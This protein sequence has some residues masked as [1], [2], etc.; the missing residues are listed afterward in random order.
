[1]KT[2]TCA[3]CR[4]G[5]NEGVEAVGLIAYYDLDEGHPMR[6]WLC[7]QHLDMTL[8]YNDTVRV[9]KNAPGYAPVI[10]A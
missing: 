10:T 5:E 3:S 4:R 8:E 2:P 7:D 9:L 6:E 1:M